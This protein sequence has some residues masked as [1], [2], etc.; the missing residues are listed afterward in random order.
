VRATTSATNG[1]VSRAT[2]SVP[3]RAGESTSSDTRS[4]TTSAR[5]DVDAALENLGVSAFRVG[6]CSARSSELSIRPSDANR[7]RRS[8][9]VVMEFTLIR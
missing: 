4:A 3:E 8:R 6:R 1:P 2:S 5:P 7:S 9:G